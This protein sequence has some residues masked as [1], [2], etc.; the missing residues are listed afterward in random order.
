MIFSFIYFYLYYNIIIM[1]IKF[2]AD[3]PHRIGRFIYK[4]RITI[5]CEHCTTD[6]VTVKLS[7]S[8]W[9]DLLCVC[10]TTWISLELFSNFMSAAQINFFIFYVCWNFK[11]LNSVFSNILRNKI[12][13][14]S[15]NKFK[16][17]CNLTTCSLLF[18]EWLK[19]IH[20]HC[21]IIW[22]WEN[23]SKWAGKNLK[24]VEFEPLCSFFT[25][26]LQFSRIGIKWQRQMKQESLLNNVSSS[27]I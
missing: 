26:Y 21:P 1:A 24:L 19:P 14:I 8:D 5:E 23:N 20:V 27:E 10:V 4:W 17:D 12:L 3:L 6:W 7:N 11:C 15:L 18:S 25:F 16:K 22:M 2:Y 9:M 13:S